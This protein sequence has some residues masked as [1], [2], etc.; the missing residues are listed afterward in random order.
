ML[1]PPQKKNGVAYKKKRV[2]T[3]DAHQSLYISR[4]KPFHTFVD[5]DV[6]GSKKIFMVAGNMLDTAIILS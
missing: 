6:Q 4:T 1:T 2:V 5:W 3:F